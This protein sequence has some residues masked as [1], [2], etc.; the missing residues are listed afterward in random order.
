MHS[1]RLQRMS[2]PHALLTSLLEKPSS[3]FELRRRFENSIGYFWRATHQQIYRE[4]ARMEAMGWI[5]SSPASDAGQT[6][7]RCYRVLPAGRRELE[8]WTRAPAE[9]LDLRDPLLVKLRASAQLG[10]IDLRKELLR[11]MEQH[12]S[13]LA[14]YMEIS[15]RD[16]PN[17][18]VLSPSERIQFLLLRKG[19]LYEETSLVWTHELMNVF[20]AFHG[21]IPEQSISKKHTQK[22]VSARRPNRAHAIRRTPLG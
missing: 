7:K 17:P 2:L 10:H 21:E 19:I 6:R 14:T 16:F 15:Q 8:I 20:N 13:Q 12:Q 1:S 4:L 22:P 3:G 5:A 18:E 11:H 9:S